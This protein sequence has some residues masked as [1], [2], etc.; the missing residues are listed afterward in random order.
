MRFSDRIIFS[1]LEKLL[2]E[3]GDEVISQVEIANAAE[4]SLSATQRALR[5]L[6]EQE[7]I[8][9]QF[10]SGIGYKYRIADGCTSQRRSA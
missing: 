10:E 8:I 2:A 7:R 1:T 6:M 9:G 4:V 5:R 3:R